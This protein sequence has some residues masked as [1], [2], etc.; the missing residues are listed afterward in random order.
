MSEALSLLRALAEMDE[1]LQK[2][3]GRL[4]DIAREEE[5]LQGRIA[6]VDEEFARRKEEHRRLRLAAQERT[7]EVDATDAK[8]REYQRKLEFD[9]IPYKEM[10][11][12]REQVQVLRAKL[13]EL[14]EQAI[15]LMEA[16]EEDAKKLSQDEAAYRERRAQL[17]EEMK[18]LGRKREELRREQEALEAKR[19]EL[20]AQLPAQLRQH[21][22]NLR[23]RFPN[24]VAYVNGQTCGGCHLRLSEATLLRLHEGREVVTCEHCSRFLVLRWA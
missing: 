21:Y 12:L 10:E 7:T 2:L 16:V 3:T 13:D 8:I 24:P 1:A 18:G 22:Q 20:I 5:Y 23:A 11:F 15:K 4:A 6:Q 17:E 14:S 9:I 19:E